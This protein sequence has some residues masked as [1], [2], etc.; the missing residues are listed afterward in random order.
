MTAIQPAHLRLQAS[1]LAQHFNNPQAF[2]HQLHDLLSLYA[3]HV[4]RPGQTGNP[5]ILL[6]MYRVPQPVLRQIEIELTPSF[7][8]YTQAGIRLCD[9]LWNESYYEFK[10][11]AA[12]CIGKIPLENP[13]EGLTRIYSWS[14]QIKDKPLQEAL[15]KRGLI[16]IIT[17]DSNRMI[18]RAQSWLNSTQTSEE[19]FGVQIILACLADENFE[20]LPLVFRML[21][22]FVRES[23]NSLRSSI[24]EVLLNLA[25]RTPNETAYFLQQNIELSFDQDTAWFIRRCLSAFPPQTQDSLRGAI[26]TQEQRQSFGK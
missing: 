25:H 22:P 9:A 1:Q 23:H 5:A 6:P 18:N 10:L 15:Y 16:T 17:R 24:I 20:N 4:Y 26:R 13:D 14:L 12:I 7:E 8:K 11:L 3:R 19:L 21:A 2:I